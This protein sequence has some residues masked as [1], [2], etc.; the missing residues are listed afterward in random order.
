MSHVY[1]A[2]VSCRIKILNENIPSCISINNLYT[3]FRKW[4]W[5]S[6]N[7]FPACDM[8]IFKYN[9]SKILGQ[10]VRGKFYGIKFL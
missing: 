1:D 6:Y 10:P 5:E 2:F 7:I 3:E 4:Y 9:I 8:T